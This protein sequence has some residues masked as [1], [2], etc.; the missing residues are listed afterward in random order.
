MPIAK[1]PSDYDLII[2]GTPV[3]AWNI[4][5]PIRAYIEG[6][7]EKFAKLAVFCTMGG[8]G[9]VKA[10]N[11]IEKLC[12]KKAIARLTLKTKEAVAGDYSDKLEAFCV[13]L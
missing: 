11:E 9:D 3:W 10:F 5:S 1:N 12:G 8:D 2:I 6:N 7:K 13:S 4:S